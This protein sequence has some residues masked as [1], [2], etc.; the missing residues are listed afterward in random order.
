MEAFCSE[1]VTDIKS[2]KSEADLIKVIGGS[3]ARLR[4]ERHSFNESGYLMNIILCLRNTNPQNLSK[5]AL[6]NIQ[7][8]IAIFMQFQRETSDRIC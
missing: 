4:K 7:L 3:M 1:I 8:A 2:A 6:N 5:E